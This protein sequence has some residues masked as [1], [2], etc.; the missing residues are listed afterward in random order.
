MARPWRKASGNDDR[1]GGA[2]VELAL[3]VH[4]AAVQ[5]DQALDDRQAEAGA[6][7]AA[8]IGLAGLEERIADPLQIV[9][10]DADAGVG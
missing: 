1:H 9:G 5:A 10:G 6:L 4:L 3:H 2:F 8:L 7:V